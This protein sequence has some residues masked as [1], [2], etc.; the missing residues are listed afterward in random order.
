MVFD[1]Q[2]PIIGKDQALY[3]IQSDDAV[4]AHFGTDTTKTD[5]KATA[6]R[7]YTADMF[8]R[9]QWYLIGSVTDNDKIKTLKI[10]GN[11]LVTYSDN[12]SL[13]ANTIVNGDTYSTWTS[14]D[15][16]TVYFKYKL[17]T[18]T[19]VGALSFNIYVEDQA[20]PNSGKTTKEMSVK[21]DNQEPVLAGASDS[22][23]KIS[24][25]VVQNNGF[26]RLESKVL[27]DAVEGKAQSGLDFVAFYFKRGNKIYNPM[28]KNA[29]AEDTSSDVS[30]ADGL[31]WKKVTV[32]RSATLN[33]LK[34]TDGTGIRKGG[35][36]K[37][38]GTIYSITDK[39]ANTVTLNGN[40]PELLTEA[41]FAI[42]LFADHDSPETGSTARNAA[43]YPSTIVNDDGDG[44]VEYVEKTGTSYI[45]WA[46]I[47]SKNIP[48]GPIELH[49]VA[50]DKAGNYQA[51]SD[52]AAFVKNNAPRL[53]AVQVWTDYNG[54]DIPQED[55]KRTKYCN[56]LTD[57]S[58][59]YINYAGGV[60]STLIASGNGKD[61]V[62]AEGETATGT[63][64][65]TI[66]DK[67]TFTPEIVGGNNALNYKSRIGKA[68]ALAEKN[69]DGTYKK[70][71]SALSSELYGENWIGGE[72][73]QVE[74]EEYM[75][76]SYVDL[77]KTRH[78]DIVFGAVEDEWTALGSA[79]NSRRRTTT[80]QTQNKTRHCVEQNPLHGMRF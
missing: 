25:T 76:G 2:N 65:M 47:V 11:T 40:P 43:G 36:V 21:F 73:V 28:E 71:F 53:A 58:G 52:T 9:G 44:M 49:Y 48:D 80:T 6:S 50:Y 18:S 38:G 67:T 13:G 45:W 69:T 12:T 42:A 3:L 41:Y 5:F 33:Q 60:T 62:A 79:P 15:K 30:L 61:Y 55:E 39:T 37:L 70:T 56:Q 34:F 4:G 78:G 54:D 46:E 51:G 72:N 7:E 23:Y 29:Y 8:V 64:F 24:S 68:S 66:R 31:Y 19:G 26:Y 59:N 14:A 77:T 1:A 16:S 57:I 20:T 75:N 32:E 10:D 74:T 22:A 35:K 27:E 63:A 17:S